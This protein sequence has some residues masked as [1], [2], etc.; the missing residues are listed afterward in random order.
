MAGVTEQQ[1]DLFQQKMSIQ[2]KTGPDLTQTKEIVWGGTE[3]MT[4]SLSLNLQCVV[5][6]NK[7]APLDEDDN[8]QQRFGNN[9]D[10]P[11]GN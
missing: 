4:D 10:R 5:S 3:A 1:G 7:Q 2:L 8:G 6:T 9:A 11:F